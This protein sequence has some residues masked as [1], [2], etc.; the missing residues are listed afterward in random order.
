MKLFYCCL[1]YIKILKFD[2]HYTC[3]S[4]ILQTQKKTH[5]SERLDD[6]A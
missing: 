4:K 3:H 2:I 1:D 6:L 5:V